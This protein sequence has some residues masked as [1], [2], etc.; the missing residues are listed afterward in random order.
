MT[1]KV[2]GEYTKMTKEEQ[3]SF[4]DGY[5][6]A[7]DMVC[8]CFDKEDR[9][10]HKRALEFSKSKDIDLKELDTLNAELDELATVL[11]V[12]LTL[13]DK[14]PIFNGDE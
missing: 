4:I 6:K 5:N 13:R 11:K 3:Q 2:R 9:K 14:K 10:H 7:I 8:A 1:R 12:I